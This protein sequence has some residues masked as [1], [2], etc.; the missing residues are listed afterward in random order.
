MSDQ[1]WGGRF[2]SPA[3]PSLLALSR[4]PDSYFRM[5]PYDLAGSRSHV[6]ELR[7]AGILDEGEAERLLAAIDTLDEDVRAGRVGPNDSD[8]DVH[9]FLE[10]VLVERLGEVGGKLRAGR[11]RN[12]LWVA[13]L[14]ES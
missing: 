13:D 9:T 1:L 7:R 6:R 11:S 4:A 10:R 5:S 8:E 14:T 12:D 2:R 3:D